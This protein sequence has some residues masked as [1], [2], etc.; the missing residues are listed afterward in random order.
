[1][2]GAQ[3]VAGAQ[4][5][6]KWWQQK[7]FPSSQAGMGPA[8]PALVVG[9]TGTCCMEA[10]CD[11][12][13]DQ[14][15][16]LRQRSAARCHHPRGD[17]SSKK[18]NTSSSNGL[19][20]LCSWMTASLVKQGSHLQA[21]AHM[22]LSSPWLLL[23]ARERSHSSGSILPR[24]QHERQNSCSNYSPALLPWILSL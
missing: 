19:G 21:H 23:T 7:A 3:H 11:N 10:A 5:S 14:P 4:Q 8:D 22:L 24:V 20:E 13:W 2:Q 1:M 15:D 16:H 17:F 6:R 9:A 18:R 12:H